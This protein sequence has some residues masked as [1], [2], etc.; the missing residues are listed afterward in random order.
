MACA[1]LPACGIRAS[2]TSSARASTRPASALPSRRKV[3]GGLSLGGLLGMGAPEPAASLPLAPLGS[4]KAVGGAK[5]R[6]LSVEQ[7]KDQ[8]EKDL[9]EGQYFVTAGKRE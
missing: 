2:S 7:I 3:L 6:D 8:L 5:R 1:V 9:T 4:V